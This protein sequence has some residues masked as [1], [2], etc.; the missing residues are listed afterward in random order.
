MQDFINSVRSVITEQNISDIAHEASSNANLLSYR[1]NTKDA[2]NKA[3]DAHAIAYARHQNLK[4]IH[5]GTKYANLYHGSYMQHHK[6]MMTY[7]D[8]QLS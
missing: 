4:N 3:N 5:S 1:A 7:H 6:N 2:H 8:S